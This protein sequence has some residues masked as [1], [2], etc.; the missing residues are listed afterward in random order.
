MHV[1]AE[2][3]GADRRAENLAGMRQKRPAGMIQVVKVVIV[4]Q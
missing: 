4:R 2:S 3:V 1:A